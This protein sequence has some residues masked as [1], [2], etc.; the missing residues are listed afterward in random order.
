MVVLPFVLA[1]FSASKGTSQYVHLFGS[2]TSDPD[3]AVQL[4]ETAASLDSDNAGPDLAAA[5]RLVSEKRWAEAVPHFRNSVEKG[6]GVSVVYSY[7]ANAQEQAGDLPA[8]V[9]TLRGSIEIFP[10]SVFLRIRYTTVLEKLGRIAD[11]SKQMEIARSIDPRQANGWY[12]VIKDGILYAHIHA[13]NDPTIYAAP[14]DLLPENAIH[15]YNDQKA[16]F[17]ESK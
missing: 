2:Q 16:F 10:R 1:L 7:L 12:S 8:A 17:D 9:E 13:T 11:A 4:F 15:A 5:E 3:E 6:F 14:P